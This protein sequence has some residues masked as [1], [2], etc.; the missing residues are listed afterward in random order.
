MVLVH[1][2]KVFSV[3]LNPQRKIMVLRL[4]VLY[5]FFGLLEISNSCLVAQ[6]APYY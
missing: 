2:F 3:I 6:M 1:K 4:N 5:Y